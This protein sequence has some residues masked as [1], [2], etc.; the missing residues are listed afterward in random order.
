[1]TAPLENRELPRILKFPGLDF[2]AQFVFV[3][4]A[5]LAALFTRS[6]YV[7]IISDMTKMKSI[8]LSYPYNNL[9]ARRHINSR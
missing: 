3:G 6:H 9:I 1:M 5:K 8:G 7:Y 2:V 4:K